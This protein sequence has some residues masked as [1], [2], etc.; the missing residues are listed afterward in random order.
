M[1]Y[2]FLATTVSWACYMLLG[3]VIFW[4]LLT[5]LWMWCLDRS[6]KWEE[7]ELDPKSH[8]CMFIGYSEESKAFHLYDLTSREVIVWRDV[9]FQKKSLFSSLSSPP[10]D[11][12]DVSFTNAL[13]LPRL[14][15]FMDFD[16]HIELMIRLMFYISLD[17]MI[18]LI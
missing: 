6:S 15:D 7:E 18:W 2:I 3:V 12:F 17:Q 11:P 4:L 9:V 8:K 5:S 10:H 14:S 1:D 13:S 16:D